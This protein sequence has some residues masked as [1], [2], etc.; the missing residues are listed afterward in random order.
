MRFSKKKYKILDDI[1]DNGVLLSHGLR[2]VI[3]K[4]G[5]DGEDM[6]SIF[7]GFIRTTINDCKRG[8]FLSRQIYE[9]ISE[10]IKIQNKLNEFLHE[11]EPAN[12]IMLLPNS[13]FLGI[14]NSI[15]YAIGHNEGNKSHLMF[16]MGFHSERGLEMFSTGWFLNHK[17]KAFNAI[18]DD[19]NFH[20]DKDEAIEKFINFMMNIL[21]FMQFAEIETVITEGKQSSGK[22]KVKINNEKYLN[23]STI[24]IEIIDSNWFRRL[25]RTGAFKV[26]GHFRLQP[27]GKNNSQRKLIW[28]SEYE[29][30]GYT[31]NPKMTKK[32]NEK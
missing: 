14:V 30:S 19:M 25:I 4:L 17:F 21:L 8:Y 13:N 9:M 12:G 11:L 28:I 22:S 3:E 23:E 2:R 26:N 18:A 15:S 20:I 29:K 32:G 5:D 31:L 24:P 27:Y 10:D 16:S 7:H 1:G 6:K